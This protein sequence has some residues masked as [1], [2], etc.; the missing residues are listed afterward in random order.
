MYTCFFL[1]TITS[2]TIKRGLELVSS[3]Q[4]TLIV[5]WVEPRPVAYVTLFPELVAA[6]VPDKAYLIYDDWTVH[7]IGVTQVTGHRFLCLGEL[8]PG[9]C[10]RA[11]R[12]RA[13]GWHSYFF[14][15]LFLLVVSFHS[16]FFLFKTT[17]P[18]GREKKP[19]KKNVIVSRKKNKNKRKRR[20]TNKQKK[21]IKK[22]AVVGKKKK[23]KKE[24]TEN[25]P[26]VMRYVGT[27]F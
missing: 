15:S 10:G 5:N 2:H 25:S 24:K 18:R 12:L 3:T 21:E 27:F 9:T 11:C 8:I 6:I 20:R 17:I 4:H 14:S 13:A 26:T 19:T 1:H 22:N 23:M 16:F 7:E